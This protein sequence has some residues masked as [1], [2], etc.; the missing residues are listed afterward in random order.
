MVAR[1]RTRPM[2]Y[3]VAAVNGEGRIL[4]YRLCCFDANTRLHDSQ[5]RMDIIRSRTDGFTLPIRLSNS[6]NVGTYEAESPLFNGRFR[7][8]HGRANDRLSGLDYPLA[9]FRHGTD[10]HGRNYFARR[11]S[12]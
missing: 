1:R 12:G 6:W 11:S 8:S 7:N 2:D 9:Q 3:G 5:R 4:L 10:E